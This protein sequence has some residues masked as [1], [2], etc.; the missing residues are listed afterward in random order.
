MK[1]YL[2]FFL[3]LLFLLPNIAFTQNTTIDSLKGELKNALDS[4]QPKLLVDLSYAFG[5]V[6]EWDSSMVYAQRARVKAEVL[7]DS[8]EFSRSLFRISTIYSNQNDSIKAGDYL[9]Q[10]KEIRSRYGYRLDDDNGLGRNRFFNNLYGTIYHSLGIFEDTSRQLTYEQVKEK[11]FQINDSQDGFDPEAVYWFKLRIKGEEN[12]SRKYYFMVG[13]N[14][15]SWN[16]VD[17]YYQKGD[18]VIFQRS[19]FELLAAEKSEDFMYNFVSVDLEA[20]EETSLYIR[21]EELEKDRMPP[22]LS[23]SYIDYQNATSLGG[24]QFRGE[25]L[26]PYFRQ[27]DYNSHSQS[28]ELVADSLGTFSL[29]EVKSIWKQKARFQSGK[30]FDK[31]WVYWAK[32]KIIGNDQFYGSHLFSVGDDFLWGWNKIDVY[33]PNQTAGYDYQ[34]TGNGLPLWRKYRYHKMNLFTV[35]VMPSD[36]MEVY[37][38]LEDINKFYSPNWINFY[39][40]NKDTFWTRY[41]GYVIGIVFTIGIFIVS[42]LYFLLFFFR[43][44]K[45]N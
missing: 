23:I 5:N 2:K 6:Q 24:Y 10:F 12:R 3:L 30:D 33:V 18:S 20:G 1:S 36:T 16:R 26:S 17:A 41:I 35:D 38:R 7:N 27:Y 32:L 40:Y 9:R 43:E 45:K 15:L 44:M 37:L 19:G 28:I 25:Y 4:L 39:H 42:F 11:T 13:S 8:L 31:D 34:L 22:L 29:E 14:H 21:V